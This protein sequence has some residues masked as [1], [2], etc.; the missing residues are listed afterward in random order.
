MAD[1]SLGVNLIG[2]DV[3][4]SSALRELARH[5][6]TVSDQLKDSGDVAKTS[7]GHMSTLAKVGIAAAA[8]GMVLAAKGAYDFAKASVSAAQESQ[9][10]DARLGQIAK[11]M[12]YVDGAYKGGIARVGEYA[13]SL[14]KSIGVE[15]ESIKAV[16]SKL[17]TFKAVG[18]TMNV[19][20]GA[21]DRATKAAYDLASAGF[22]TAEGN[23]TQLGK[24]LQDP[25]KGI[26]SLSK[27]GVTFT[28]V[29]KDKMKALVE[30]GH[31]AEAQQMI[32]KAIETQV[33]G[34]AEKT[35]TAGQKM[36]V[37][38]GELQEKIGNS[39][40]PV[41]SKIADA[42]TPLFENLQGPL[43]KV[44]DMVGGALSK[45]FDALAPVLPVLAEAL[46]KIAGVLGTVLSTAITALIP[47]V[48]PLL[49]L[50][51]DLASRIGPLLAPLLEKIGTLLTTLMAAV[52][53]LLQPLTEVVFGILD[54]AGPILGVAVD[55]VTSLVR[56]LGPVL[57]AV[58]QLIGPLGQL[59]NVVLS[60]IMP[61]IEPLLPV[62]DALAKVLGDVL[63]RAVGVI[64]T[65]LG[66]LIEGWSKL[67]PFILDNVARPVVSIFLDMVEKLVDGAATAFGWIPGLGDKLK[68]AA[69][70]IHGFKDSAT[71]AI[72]DAAKTIGSKGYEIGQG[73]VDNGVAMMT[74]PANSAKAKKAGISLGT[75]LANGVK[76]GVDASAA[77]LGLSTAALMHHAEKSARDASQTRSPSKVFQKIG[78]DL[79]DGLDL[80]VTE[81]TETLSSGITRAMQAAI[82]AA[83]A[84]GE[85]ADFT[86]SMATVMNKI[87]SAFNDKLQALKTKLDEATTAVTDWSKNMASNIASGFDIEAAFKGQVDENGKATG[88]TWMDGVNAQLAKMQWFGN[89][90]AAVKANGGSDELVSYL[91]SKGADSGGAMGE[92]LIKDGLIKTM[93]DK[94]VEVQTQA[95]AIADLLIPE[96][97]RAG[98]ESAQEQYNGLKAALGKGGKVRKAIMDLMDNLADAMRRDA[99][100]DVWVTKHVQTIESTVNAATGATTTVKGATGGLVTRPTYALIGE[101]G[102]EMV[103]PLN[104]TPGS[105]PLSSLG[106][107]G[108]GNLTVNVTVQGS[109]V[110]EQ[111][112]AIS[113][114]DQIAQL[115][116]RRGLNPAILGV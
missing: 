97:L 22:G 46:G 109:V 18:D 4:A 9:V 6:K 71:S 30:T 37:S 54:A 40:L 64:M 76:Q 45:A 85:K 21:M 28:Q 43:G 27:S 19:A 65:A 88:K 31:A 106:G 59:I 8:G 113:V 20:G 50:F 56:A 49:T 98:V 52:M 12:G 47:V 39:L 82:N 100:I 75:D 57:G 62:I 96:S 13:S 104:S 114:R 29:E 89:V 70:A 36:K 60:A 86:D 74:D 7:N 58:G 33:G 61:I 67:A 92:G 73:L 84:A 94:M 102:P 14:S 83:K 24:A 11:S 107:N 63:T 1:A 116:R 80:G 34:T 87:T 103:I 93:S 48:T 10:A 44:A 35:A 25:I 17:L 105:S 99:S 79:V 41:I 32:L 68:G 78:N 51:G 5:A 110:Q 26:A 66:Y 72:N 91:A 111:D 90:L 108:T 81:K 115:M 55:A 69:D 53:P 38:F 101:A 42:L 2:R 112:L 3:S 77:A 95:A 15:D 16:Q 23:A